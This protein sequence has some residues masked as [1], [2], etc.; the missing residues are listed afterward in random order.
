VNTYLS[1][2]EGQNK[3]ILL[4]GGSGLIG[5]M[6]KIMAEAEGNKV[7][8]LSRNPAP[9]QSGW[10]P[11]I[12]NMEVEQPQ[13]YDAI[14]NLAGSSIADGRWTA[15]R[16]KDI[17]QSRLDSAGTIEKYIANG[18]LKTRVY[19]G[20]SGIGIYG[21]R[22]ET[23]VNED[24]SIEISS[25]WLVNIA[26]QW[27][28]AHHRMESLGVRT[29]ILRTGIV[30]SMEGGALKEVLMPARYGVLT[31]FGNGRQYWPW[32]HI[33]DVAGIC[34]R[35]VR[36][37]S[38]SGVYLAV[39]PHPLSNRQFTAEI[40]HQFALRRLV[41]PVPRWVMRVMFGE[42]HRVL[43]DSCHALPARLTQAQYNFRFGHL[44]SALKDLWGK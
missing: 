37:E 39:S 35:A 9:G 4:A 26:A 25:D 11:A 40:N 34:L 36:D 42:M 15:S 20:M 16:K 6:I 18:L 32:I 21:D 41:L 38:W 43:F 29:V 17:I 24:T 8:V 12:R 33:L 10:N 30:L 28:A 44:E 1:G 3:K 31:C 19:I 14:I 13:F 7:I 23:Q 22:G 5:R 27:E 2:V